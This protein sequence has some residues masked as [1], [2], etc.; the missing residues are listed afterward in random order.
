[1]HGTGLQPWVGLNTNF[2]VYN[3]LWLKF[4]R[5][6]TQRLDF[7]VS[8]SFTDVTAPASPLFADIPVLHA[9]FPHD[10]FY[11]F[12]SSSAVITR[13]SHIMSVILL[14]YICLYWFWYCIV[15]LSFI[16]KCISHFSRFS[17]HLLSN[18]L[19]SWLRVKRTNNE[20]HFIDWLA[21][22]LAHSNEEY[23]ENQLDTS[24]VVGYQISTFQEEIS[25][26]QRH[27]VFPL[28]HGVKP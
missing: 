11:P 23:I 8:V 5:S 26:K 21:S 4:L 14:S 7:S 19:I 9:K 10:F 12:V 2:C 15:R 22:D 20:S 3:N 28:I 18:V 25:L 13:A 1:M 24:N 27:R 16:Y 17:V 6:N